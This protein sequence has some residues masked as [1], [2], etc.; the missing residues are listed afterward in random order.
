MRK[1]HV[2]D[3][4]VTDHS[5]GKRKPVG[6]ITDRD[7]VIE[8]VAQGLHPGQVLVEDIMEPDLLTVGE[9]E[10]LSETIGKMRA[11][12]VRRVP[13][14]DAEGALAGIVCVDDLVELLAEELG[15]LA[16]VISREQKHEAEL[17]R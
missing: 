16:K 10:G 1:H 11:K 3:L 7:I 15:D 9:Q 8:V 5:N 13:V 12:A 14:V 17:R 6:I 2:G 4:I